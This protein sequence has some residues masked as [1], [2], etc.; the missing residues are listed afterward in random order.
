MLQDFSRVF[1]PNLNI[2]ERKVSKSVLVVRRAA[3]QGAGDTLNLHN[4][5]TTGPFRKTLARLEINFGGALH[6]GSR[7][8]RTLASSSCAVCS[9][10]SR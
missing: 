9:S 3:G 8:P 7:P 5:T 2:V 6:F 10:R 4:Q 1:N